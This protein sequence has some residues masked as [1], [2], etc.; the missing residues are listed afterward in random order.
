MTEAERIK[1]IDKFWL[2]FVPNFFQLLEWLLIIGF[3]KYLVEQYNLVLLKALL[4][5]SYLF[6]LF[7][8]SSGL[9]STY[10]R[11]RKFRSPQMEYF[12]SLLISTLFIL[13]FMQICEK[14]VNIIA[15]AQK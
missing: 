2:S 14:M 12:I 6:L 10:F 3:L 8:V 5:L 4:A 13:L 1:S 11:I 9:Y 15:T 7:Y